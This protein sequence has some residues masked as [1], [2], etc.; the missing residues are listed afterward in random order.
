MQRC[1]QSK[2]S[3]IFA[4]I[5]PRVCTLVLFI[6]SGIILKII[7]ISYFFWNNFENNRFTCI[8]LIYSEIILR[9]IDLSS[10]FS[11]IILKVIDLFVLFFPE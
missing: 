2:Y 3:N 8:Y 9:I 7:E 5:P 1:F 4:Q 10:F 6:Y 11:R